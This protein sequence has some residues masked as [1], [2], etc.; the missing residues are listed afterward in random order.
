MTPHEQLFRLPEPDEEGTVN[1]GGYGGH[2]AEDFC[3]DTICHVPFGSFVRDQDGVYDAFAKQGKYLPLSVEECEREL[4]FWDDLDTLR[5]PGAKGHG[6]TFDATERVKFVKQLI[7]VYETPDT[8]D[9]ELHH[10][11]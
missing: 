3:H 10:I 8:D 9:G 6:I 5:D 11:D 1:V 4:K 2:P 7:K